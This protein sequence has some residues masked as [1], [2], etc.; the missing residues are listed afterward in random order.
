MEL[1]NEPAI[2]SIEDEKDS[3][4]R[5][6]KRPAEDAPELIVEV[7]EV[8][9]PQE[10][11]VKRQKRTERFPAEIKVRPVR[12]RRQSSYSLSRGFL[13]DKEFETMEKQYSKQEIRRAAFYDTSSYSTL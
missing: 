2:E 12:E 10:Q 6:G 13:D 3:A 8:E 4:L 11:K 5:K 7:I 1:V 9:A